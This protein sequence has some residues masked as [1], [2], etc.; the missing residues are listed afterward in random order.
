MQKDKHETSHQNYNEAPLRRGISMKHE[1]A[2]TSISDVAEF[3]AL[4]VH[5]AKDTSGINL[6]LP[7]QPHPLPGL[8]HHDLDL[9]CQVVS[10]RKDVHE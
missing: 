7:G 5:E 2:R 9:V 8:L 4:T 1:N 10:S 3:A 6:L